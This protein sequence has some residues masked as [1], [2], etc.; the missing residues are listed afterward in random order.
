MV[1]RRRRRK[2]QKKKEKRVAWS[3]RRGRGARVCGVT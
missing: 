1:R 2:K 3:Q